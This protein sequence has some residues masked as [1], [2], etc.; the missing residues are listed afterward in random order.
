MGGAKDLDEFGDTV[1]NLCSGNGAQEGTV[2]DGRDGLVVATEAVLEAIE[3]DG[4][5]IGD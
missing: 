2:D 3:V 4:D 5:T 1:A